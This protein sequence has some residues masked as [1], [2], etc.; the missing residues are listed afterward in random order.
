ML[1][2]HQLYRYWHQ[3][4]YSKTRETSEDFYSK[5]NNKY[6]IIYLAPNAGKNLPEQTRLRPDDCDKNLPERLPMEIKQL[7]F[8]EFIQ[9]WL[10]KCQ[11]LLEKNHRIREYIAQYQ[12]L[13]KYL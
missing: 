4:I 5:N 9:E 1:E 11:Q 6:Q 3:V 12:M 7:Y 13:C 10:E 2:F 8:N